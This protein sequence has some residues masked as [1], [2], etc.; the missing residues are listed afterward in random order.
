MVRF[1]YNLEALLQYREEI[2]ERERELLHR[3]NYQ[4]QLEHNIRTELSQK[5][6]QTMR[7]MTVA[8]MDQSEDQELEWFQRYMNRLCFEIRECEARM[9]KLKSQI[10]A[11]KQVVIEAAK[12]K[13]ILASMKTRKERAFWME[14]E[15][16]E[17]KEID[18]LVVT[19]YTN[20]EGGSGKAEDARKSERTA[21]R[22]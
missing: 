3:L 8:C 1:K 6:E 17:Q 12:N 14:V 21:E 2:E 18:E 4:Y 19:R 5:L 22:E 20:A 16:R 11:Q 9:T 15:R 10:A 13:K 7:E